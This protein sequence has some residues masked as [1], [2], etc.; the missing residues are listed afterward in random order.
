MPSKLSVFVLHI[1]AAFSLN[2]PFLAYGSP[3][4]CLP[5]LLLEPRLISTGY[6]RLQQKTRPLR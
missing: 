5:T 4:P 6:F 2:V 3:A 1:Y